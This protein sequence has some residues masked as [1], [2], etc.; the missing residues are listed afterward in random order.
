MQS[1]AT[2]EGHQDQVKQLVKIANGVPAQTIAER[3]EN[4]ST[5][6]A[7]W[8]LGVQSIQGYLARAPETVELK[9]DRLHLTVA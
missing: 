1:L 5:M 8:Q 4:A 7:L 3:V 9:G 6:A 2:N